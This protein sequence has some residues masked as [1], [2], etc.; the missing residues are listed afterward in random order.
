MPLEQKP[1][2]DAAIPIK[3]LS[4]RHVACVFLLDTSASME[5]EPIK[6]LNEGIRIFKEQTVN[7][8]KFN[9]H[10]KA[11]IDVAIVSFDST[12][13]VY[14]D[15]T[16]VE[17]MSVP[18]LKAG[19]MTHMGEALEKAMD[20]ITKQKERYNS[21]GTPYYRPWIFC[22]T[23]GGPND[24]YLAAM[25]R[26]EWMENEKKLLAYCVGVDGFQKDIVKTIF[27]PERI[28]KLENLDF[29]SLFQFVSSSL[30]A[31]RNSNEA[32]GGSIEVD[33]P[34]TIKMVF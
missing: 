17:N 29:P 20:M 13:K 22:I 4:E 34:K 18:T 12:I 9:A 30:A 26:L 6:K 32:D 7:N 21:M 28:F 10:T 25:Q 33:A 8:V 14:Q 2:N 15:F 27:A 24:D 5:G 31:V 23:D 19:G 1:F 11:C 3:Y 16:P